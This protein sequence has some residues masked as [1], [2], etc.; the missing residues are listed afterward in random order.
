MPTNSSTLLEQTTVFEQGHNCPSC[1]KRLDAAT[2]YPSDDWEWVKP[3]PEDL[4]VCLYCT[5]FLKFEGE[6]LGLVLLTYE[7]IAA[8]P[9]DIRSALVR[10]RE[11]IGAHF[12]PKP[13]P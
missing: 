3:K 9:S 4:T 12:H 7:E 8:L 11:T 13:Q 10:A 1:G 6:Q 2:P 5:S